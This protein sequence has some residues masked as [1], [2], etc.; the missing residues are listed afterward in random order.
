MSEISH[1]DFKNSFISNIFKQEFSD[2]LRALSS[3]FNIYLEDEIS[4]KEFTFKYKWRST[5]EL[6]KF[7]LKINGYLILMVPSDPM[8]SKD[9]ILSF[10]YINLPSLEALKKKVKSKLLL[11]NSNY[12]FAENDEALQ[13]L[14]DFVKVTYDHLSD[15]RSSLV[16]HQSHVYMLELQKLSGLKFSDISDIYFNF[17][18]KKFFDYLTINNFTGVPAIDKFPE[19][20]AKSSSYLS[21]YPIVGWELERKPDGYGHMCGRSVNIDWLSKEINIEGWSS[22]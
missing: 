19:I 1:Q 2:F 5:V 22:D 21:I 18:A 14:L 11:K 16:N 13:E 7:R 6:V 15:K 17:S 4:K 3:N 20:S 9:P 8:I 10:N 12:T